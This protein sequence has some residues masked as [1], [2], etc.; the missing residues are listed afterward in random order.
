M[1]HLKYGLL[2]LAALLMAGCAGPGY[3]SSVPVVDAEADAAGDREDSLPAYETDSGYIYSQPPARP[4]ENSAVI[5][6]L[7]TA[8]QQKQAADY[9][10]AAASLERAIRISPRDPVLYYQLAEVRYLQ[11]NFQQ[12]EQLCRKA[13]SLAGSNRELTARS[14][15][16]MTR[17]QQAAKA[18]Y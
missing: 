11:R 1:R 8:G 17:A 18:G 15:T 9:V 16:L 2:G 7:K 6:L 4:A 5:A 14:R 10:S 12:A 13:I 3:Y